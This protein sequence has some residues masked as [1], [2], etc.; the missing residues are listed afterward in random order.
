MHNE[1]KSE[2]VAI[3]YRPIR[4]THTRTHT[5]DIKISWEQ[6]LFLSCQWTGKKH[7]EA[8]RRNTDF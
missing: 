1:R 8:R 7:A 2:T 4:I 6:Y 3:Y 5:Q